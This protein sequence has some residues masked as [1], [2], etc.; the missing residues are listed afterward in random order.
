[1]DIS[2]EYIEMCSKAEEIQK[3]RSLP[4][5][6][7]YGDSFWD[8]SLSEGGK[9]VIY[10]FNQIGIK[11]TEVWLPRQDQLQQIVFICRNFRD[12]ITLPTR[13]T[14]EFHKFCSIRE[15]DSDFKFQTLEQLW[16]VFVMNRVFS[17]K[18]DIETKTWVEK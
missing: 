2:L 18:W 5:S 15:N 4:N 7:I 10:G 9:M 12:Q 16:L 1:M 3:L 17:K 8:T 14:Y 11:P 13:Q 6:T